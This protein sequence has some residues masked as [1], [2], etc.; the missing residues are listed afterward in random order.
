[1]KHRVFLIVNLY[2][3]LSKSQNTH[4]QQKNQ[5]HD[6]PLILFFNQIIPFF[7]NP[8]FHYSCIPVFQP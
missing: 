5:C 1:M 7:Q 6:G 8:S 3:L 2:S 4:L